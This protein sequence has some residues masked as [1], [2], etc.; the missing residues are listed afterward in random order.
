MDTLKTAIVV[1]LL[2]AVLYIVYTVLNKSDAGIDQELAWDQ[3]SMEPLQVDFGGAPPL[4]RG[5]FASPSEDSAGLQQRTSSSATKSRTPLTQ[6]VGND[7]GV[8]TGVA[9]PWSGSSVSPAVQTGQQEGAFSPP[10]VQP[11]EF[12]G[13]QRSEPAAA[14]E[15]LDP[16]VTSGSP[17]AMPY[18]GSELI[19]SDPTAAN[20]REPVT[21]ELAPNATGGIQSAPA[22]GSFPETTA[23]TEGALASGFSGPGTASPAGAVQP[24]DRAASPGGYSVVESRPGAGDTVAGGENSAVQPSRSMEQPANASTGMLASASMSAQDQL[25]R[26]QY[27]EALLTLSYAY[28]DP[29]LT[30]SDRESLQPL[31][32]SLAAEVI[33]STA[34]HMEPE[35]VV[36]V[37]DTL[38]N[39]ADQHQ[40][41]WQLLANINGLT[42]P[43][44][45]EAGTK[46]KVVRGPF[47]AKVDLT[48]RELTLYVRRLYAG[49]FPI[50]IGEQAPP[51]ANYSVLNKQAGQTFYLGNAQTLAA[52]DPANPYG[53][54]WIELGENL[55]IH[56][57]PKLGEA[58][59]FFHSI[60]LS[61]RDAN[62]LF[63]I[64]ARGSSV[65]VAR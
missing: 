63:G 37:D 51:P 60:S 50:E 34:H 49:R 55:G 22:A 27:Y 16:A 15:L 2:L 57:Q 13:G 7:S 12:L 38:Q 46:L 62:D 23:S 53:G 56:A 29:E 26:G 32:D 24:I 35:Y 45:V 5:G 3:P 11:G 18:G 61:P 25:A 59:Q 33:Y 52:D 19:P 1:V 65:V 41:S 6:S 20:P 48:R 28:Q 9:S 47:H 54:I 30:V 14:P 64:L 17:R 42:D 4:T 36:Q 43:N 8:V 40:V 39:I 21:S 31:L 10:P 44:G 58:S